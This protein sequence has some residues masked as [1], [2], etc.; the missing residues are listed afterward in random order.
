MLFLVIS[1]FVL[2]YLTI[3]LFTLRSFFYLFFFSGLFVSWFPFMALMCFI[4]S[5]VIFS[6]CCYWEGGVCT[7]FLL[8]FVGGMVILIPLWVG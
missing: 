2:F 1:L 8:S 7:Y 3:I 4:V 6:D 5:L